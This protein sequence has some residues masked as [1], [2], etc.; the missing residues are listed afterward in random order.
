MK[1]TENRCGHAGLQPSDESAPRFSGSRGWCRT[2]MESERNPAEH[3]H[4]WPRSGTPE[5]CTRFSRACFYPGRHRSHGAPLGRGHGRCG[6]D[7]RCRLVARA[8]RHQSRSLAG[9]AHGIT[10]GHPEPHVSS[11]CN[12]FQAI[13]SEIR[14]PSFRRFRSI[15][16][17][18]SLI[19][20]KRTLDRIQAGRNSLSFHPSSSLISRIVA[21]PSFSTSAWPRSSPFT[22]SNL[23]CHTGML[24]S[25]I[26]REVCRCNRF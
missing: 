15:R 22:F 2:G 19:S 20:A 13:G 21:R 25:L 24:C 6:N 10:R 17:F 16:A 26:M 18:D 5:P 3:G 1:D 11:N 4:A 23:F 9:V 14:G 7:D 8:S 12:L